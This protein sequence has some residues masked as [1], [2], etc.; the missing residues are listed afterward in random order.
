MKMSNFFWTE[1]AILFAAALI[2]DLAVLPY[3]LQLVRAASRRTGKPLK[4]SVPKLLIIAFLQTAILLGIAIVV[5]LLTAHSIGLGAPYLEAA[6]AGNAVG[7]A[8]L[9]ILAAAIA[10]GAL[11]GAVLTFLDLILLPHL[12]ASLLDT[13]RGIS[14]WQN[15]IASFYGGLAEEFLMRLCGFSL[16]AWLLSRIWSTPQGLPTDAV[17]WIANIVVSVLFGIGHMPALRNVVDKVTP[18]LIARALVLNGIV[19]LLYGW[20][21]WQH[22]LEAAVVAHFATDIVFHVGGTLLLRLNDRYHFFRTQTASPA[23]TI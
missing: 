5:G 4:M 19:G 11:G 3:V 6:L 23:P 10:L 13:A 14:L 15:F 8:F 21:Y 7:P 22:G 1:F 20:L 12:P 9:Q 16:L 2:G 18:L 17:F